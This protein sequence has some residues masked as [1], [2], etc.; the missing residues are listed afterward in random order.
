[1]NF[2]QGVLDKDD[3]AMRWQTIEPMYAE[4]RAKA[5][6]LTV[7]LEEQEEDE[8]D[9]VK[10]RQLRDE[11]DAAEL[12]LFNFQ[13]PFFALAA[14]V[15]SV[16]RELAGPAEQPAGA[17]ARAVTMK[18][19]KLE[20]STFD[21]SLDKWMKFKDLFEAMVHNNESLDDVVRFQYLENAIQVKGAANVLANFRFSG[22]NYRAAWTAVKDRYEDRRT[23][24]STHLHEL[25]AVKKMS[26]NT[27]VELRR[28][29][30]S[31]NANL[32]SLEQLGYP[33]IEVQDLANMLIVHLVISRLDEEIVR[34]W[35]KDRD[36]TDP[37]WADL[38]K[39]L[40]QHWRDN[41]DLEPIRKP[42]PLEQ[43]PKQHAHTSIE[44]K[45]IEL[46]CYGCAGAHGLWECG[47]FLKLTVD[48]RNE[49]VREKRLCWKCFGKHSSSH[50]KKRGCKKCSGRHHTL[51]HKDNSVMSSLDSHSIHVYIRILL[52]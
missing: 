42:K 48:A 44:K 17:G 1:V 31:V 3:C 15:K 12:A 19:P 2:E 33:L 25:N 35:R 49:F 13:K 10:K 32:K 22:D 50:C 45:T 9:E 16:L 18:T 5:T 8:E 39:F 37:T 36:T 27:A 40:L 29:L 21:G 47:E 41:Q 38:Q 30:D 51:L 11:R 26:G 14:R 52:G 20:L 23:L 34:A 24:L 7:F 28:V 46:N 4:R 6:E 43:K